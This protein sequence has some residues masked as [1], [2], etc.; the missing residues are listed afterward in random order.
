MYFPTA[1]KGEWGTNLL[2]ML[3]D[4]SG[5]YPHVLVTT[6]HSPENG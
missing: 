5:D 2:S 1:K 4:K 3:Q 6:S